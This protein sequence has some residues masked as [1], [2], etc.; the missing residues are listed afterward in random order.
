MQDLFHLKF[1]GPERNFWL[2]YLKE[3]VDLVAAERRL[4]LDDGEAEDAR[5]VCLQICVSRHFRHLKVARKS[6][7]FETVASR[8]R[9]GSRILGR[10]ART[11]SCASTM[12]PVEDCYANLSGGPGLH[13][14]ANLLHQLQAVHAVE[15]RVRLQLVMVSDLCWL[16]ATE[17]EFRYLND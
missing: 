14:R 12:I 5:E 8:P 6:L 13:R 3:R 15:S 1:L 9:N 11:P 16:A 17:R 2:R 4:L 7:T 10:T